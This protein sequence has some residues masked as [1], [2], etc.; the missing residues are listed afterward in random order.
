M[1]GGGGGVSTLTPTGTRVL[2]INL[3]P[4]GSVQHEVLPYGSI[5]EE[6]LQARHLKVQIQQK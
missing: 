4:S 3:L 6:I 2:I 1:S 5:Q